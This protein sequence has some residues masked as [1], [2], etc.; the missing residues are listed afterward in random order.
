MVKKARR[1]F[2]EL[3][4]LGLACCGL[5]AADVHRLVRLRSSNEAL[6]RKSMTESAWS[7]GDKSLAEIPRKIVEGL[8]RLHRSDVAEASHH[9][10]FHAEPGNLCEDF[11]HFAV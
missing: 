5:D 1:I 8:F 7:P 4:H 2:T 11:R 10:V 9:V 6:I 3:L